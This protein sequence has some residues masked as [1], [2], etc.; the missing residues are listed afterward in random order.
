MIINYRWK[1]ILLEGKWRIWWYREDEKKKYGY[2]KGIGGNNEEGKD[3]GGEGGGF[4][5][6]G[7]EGGGEDGK[8]KVE[9]KIKGNGGNGV[10]DGKE[11]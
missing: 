9:N 7:G 4:V 6:K 2:G 11:I 1:M 10:I 8:G 5:N 3:V